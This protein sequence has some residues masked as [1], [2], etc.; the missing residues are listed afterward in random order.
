MAAVV[1]VMMVV[2][3]VMVAATQVDGGTVHSDGSMILAQFTAT[4]TRLCACVR[5]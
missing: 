5:L 4:F 2:V 3:V 1:G